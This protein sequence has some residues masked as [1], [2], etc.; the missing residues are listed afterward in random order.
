MN[1][2]QTAQ[3]DLLIERVNALPTN[4]KPAERR[5]ERWIA[6]WG[7]ATGHNH[8]LAVEECDLYEDEAGTLWLKVPEGKTATLTHQEHAAQTF[9]P[10]VYKVTRQREFDVARD[11]ER[12][13][14]D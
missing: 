11:S 2:N 12:R 8:S 6:A 14:I 13:V 5:G 4:L 1:P 7:E 10:G 9:A 3:G